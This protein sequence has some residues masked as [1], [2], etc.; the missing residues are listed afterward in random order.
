MYY[1]ISDEDGLLLE[2]ALAW[3]QKQECCCQ[4]AQ[5]ESYRTIN[6]GGGLTVPVFL[7]SA[8]TEAVAAVSW[9]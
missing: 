5:R 2:Q 4:K 6:K 9:V 1:S 7:A 3:T 8:A